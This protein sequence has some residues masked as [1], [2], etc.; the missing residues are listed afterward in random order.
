MSQF[1]RL[2]DI[3]FL[4][5]LTIN[6]RKIKGLKTCKTVYLSTHAAFIANFNYIK[7]KLWEFCKLFWSFHL[8]YFQTEES[9]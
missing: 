2:Q 6:K 3:C 4:K 8:Y 5:T 7:L 1:K 9:M